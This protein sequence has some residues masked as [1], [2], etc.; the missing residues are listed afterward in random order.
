MGSPASHFEDFRKFECVSLFDFFFIGLSFGF[1]IVC[2]YIVLFNLL[3]VIF[4]FFPSYDS[5]AINHFNFALVL[6]ELQAPFKP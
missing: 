4:H 3:F 1:G 2:V 6:L 5:N